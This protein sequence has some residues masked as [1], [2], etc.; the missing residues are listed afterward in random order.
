MKNSMTEKINYLFYD[1]V[2]LV[3]NI[4]NN[5]LPGV[6]LLSL[7]VNYLSWMYYSAFQRVMSDG[8]ASTK[9]TILIIL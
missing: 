5:Y 7:N 6:S 9:C 1:T 2:R 3:K 4:R 8:V